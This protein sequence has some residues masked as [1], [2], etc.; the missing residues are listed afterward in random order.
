MTVFISGSL[1]AHNNQIFNYTS[2]SKEAVRSRF[3]G[4]NRRANDVINVQRSMVGKIYL[5]LKETQ[6][7]L[8]LTY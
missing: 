4:E 2:D 6:F 3:I 7:L 5:E 8:L 1:E